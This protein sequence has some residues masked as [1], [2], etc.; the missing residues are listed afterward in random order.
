MLYALSKITKKYGS[1]TI[2]DIPSMEIEK[3]AIYALLG[4]N[5]SGK[6]TLLN[7]LAFLEAPATGTIHYCFSQVIFSE[8]YLQKLR[9]DV[10]MIAQNPILFTNTVYKNVEFG[11]KIRRIPQKKRRI[12]I[13]E[14]LE[15]VG[16]NDFVQAQAHRLSGGE[17]QRIALARA[18]AVSPKVLLCDEPASSLDVENQVAIINTLKQINEQKKITIMFTTHYMYQFSSLAHHIFSLDHG[19]LRTVDTSYQVYLGDQP[20]SIPQNFIDFK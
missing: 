1:R 3:G 14:A 4:P 19:K 7:I 11:L 15:L 8:T 18:L 9:R 17:T 5:G 12:I 2:I 16:M 13:E 20:E 6:T 10:V